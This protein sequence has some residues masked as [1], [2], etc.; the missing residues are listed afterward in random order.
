MN[1][2]IL[3]LLIIIILLCFFYKKHEIIE[4]FK[5]IF[6][7]ING[8]EP[9]YEPLKWNNNIN[10][11]KSH[12][13]YSY[14]LNDISHKLSNICKK[15]NCKYINS[16]PGHYSNMTKKV[17]TKDTNCKG[18]LNRVKSDNPKIYDIDFK[19][20]CKEEYYK[21]ALSVTPQKSYHFYRQD[22][23]GYWS[24]KDGSRK[25]TNL[26]ASN[27]LIIDPKKADRKYKHS[28]FNEFCGYFCVPNNKLYKTN[29]GRNNYK[30]EVLY[31]N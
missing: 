7:P 13:C 9:L 24:G 27:K 14:M 30:E 8:Y 3:L 23:T 2:C 17:N 11:K 5:I 21:G 6:S 10:I 22:N 25:A 29:M 20:K 16:Q 28:N 1:N 15:G 26:D 12:N 18:L 4:T 19:E 31:K